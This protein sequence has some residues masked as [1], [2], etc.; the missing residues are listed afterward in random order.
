MMHQSRLKYVGPQKTTNSEQ[1]LKKMGKHRRSASMSLWSMQHL[2]NQMVGEHCLLSLNR[3]LHHDKASHLAGASSCQ[4][5]EM[6]ASQ[7]PSLQ[8]REKLKTSGLGLLVDRSSSRSLANSTQRKRL[9]AW[10]MTSWTEQLPTSPAIPAAAARFSR[11]EKKFATEAW[12]ALRRGFDQVTAMAGSMPMKRMH[13]GSSRW[14]NTATAMDFRSTAQNSTTAKQKMVSHI[15]LCI[16]TTS[17]TAAAQRQPRTRNVSAPSRKHTCTKLM[18]Q[19]ISGIGNPYCSQSPSNRLAFICWS[20]G[21]TKNSTANVAT[22]EICSKA[23]RV[24]VMSSASGARQTKP[25]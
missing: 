21:P 15:I 7:A 9:F 16:S 22:T 20:V 10:R 17:R 18:S 25:I 13:M 23:R 3:V 14:I 19:P 4:E 5:C 11:Y 6:N 8:R 24:S 2:S 1:P 12:M